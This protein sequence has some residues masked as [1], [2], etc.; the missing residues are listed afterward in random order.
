MEIIPYLSFNG[1]GD[2]AVEFYKKALGAKVNM[3][4]RFKEAPTEARAGM[5]PGS[6][7]K[8]MHAD[9]SV[10]KARL[11]LSD[12]HCTGTTSFNGISLSLQTP[13]DAETERAFHALAESGK[14]TMPFGKTFFASAFGMVTDRFGVSWMVITQQQ[15]H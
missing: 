3:L 1:R 7:N 6:E 11:F 8:I 13:T 5:T 12:G 9:L 15:G 4:M 10:G 2:E 14:V